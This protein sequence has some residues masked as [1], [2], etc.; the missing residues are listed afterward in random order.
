MRT[1]FVKAAAADSH[2]H[3][4]TEMMEDLHSIF[5]VCSLPSLSYERIRVSQTECASIRT[6]HAIDQRAGPCHTSFRESLAVDAFPAEPPV[7]YSGKVGQPEREA[8]FPALRGPILFLNCH[9]GDFEHS[10]NTRCL[11]VCHL[12][13]TNGRRYSNTFFL[14]A[15]RKVS[16]FGGSR[17]E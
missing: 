6:K 15:L 16:A 3:S 17:S 1:D 13:A 12:P 4:G 7:E 5:R 10:T 2:W 9:L 11:A 8:V 14:P